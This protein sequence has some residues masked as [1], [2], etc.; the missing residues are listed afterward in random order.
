MMN[1]Y[2]IN[3]VCLRLTF[4]R[5]QDHYIYIK[6]HLLGISE[7]CPVLLKLKCQNLNITILRGLLAVKVFL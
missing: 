4:L 7:V 1:A 2:S 6:L 3:L 5:Y